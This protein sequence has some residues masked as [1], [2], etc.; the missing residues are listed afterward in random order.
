MSHKSIPVVLT[1]TTLLIAAIATPVHAQPYTLEVSRD[2]VDGG[3]YHVE[4][5]QESYDADTILTITAVAFPGFKFV[6]W[7]G[8]IAIEDAELSFPITA[9]TSLTAVF[10]AAT[11]VDTEFE[12]TVVADPQETGFVSL[13]PAAL[14]YEPGEQ[15]TITAISASG[16]V[17]AGW[18]GDL[19]ED[20]DADAA[21][22]VV[23]MNDD[24]ELTASFAVAAEVETQ[25]EGAGNAT[26][27]GVLGMVFWPLSVL[28]LVAIRRR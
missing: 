15:V 27:C 26:G 21:E 6:G 19:P 8:D 11:E 13:D 25:A 2:P 23:V 20:A 18:T 5:D 1:L 16:Y 7:E 28:G 9:D 12:L 22:L 14:A 24:L 4:P 3:A 10:E 17:F